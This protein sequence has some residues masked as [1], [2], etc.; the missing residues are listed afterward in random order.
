MKLFAIINLTQKKN[1]D[2]ND[3]LFS[4]PCGPFY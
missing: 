3:D 2:A 4:N 1:A